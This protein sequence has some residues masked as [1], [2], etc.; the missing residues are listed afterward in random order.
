MKKQKPARKLSRKPAGQKDIGQIISR[1]SPFFLLIIIALGLWLRSADLRA[2][3]PPDLSWS[4]APYT[5]ESLNT[6][7][8]RNY[9][10]YHTFKVDDFFP[11]CVYP[12]VNIIVGFIFK[13]F[14]I[15][16]VQVKLLSVIAGV[17]GILVI[18]FFVKTSAGEI[19]GLFSSLLLATC[20]PLVM[21]SRLGLVETVQ[22]LFL[23]LA[24]LFWSKGLKKP[25]LLIFS[26]LFCAGTFLLVKLSGVFIVGA[27]FI[28]FLNQALSVLKKEIT[29]RHLLL[30]LLWFITGICLAVL[31]WLVLVFL[32]YRSE[33][34]QYVLRHSTESPAGHPRTITAY[35]FNTFTIGLRSRLF[36]RTVWMALIGYLTLPLLA[37]KKNPALFYSLLWLV[38]GMLMLGYM[39]YRPPRY[40]IILLP[41]LIIAFSSTLSN[42]WQT[43]TVIPATRPAL[44][45]T[46]ASALFFWPLC[47]QII[48]YLSGF[49]A[50]PRPGAE[51]GILIGALAL[52]SAFCLAGYLA[53]RYLRSGLVIT[54]PALRAVL[55]LI[56][57]VPTLRLDIG[58]FSDWFNNR[59]YNLIS[60]ARD[61]NQLLPEGAVVAG[62]W[63]PPLMIESR[64]RAVCVTDWANMEGLIERFGV[65]HLILGENEADM[66]LREKIDPAVWE[67]SKLVRRY[68]VRGQVLTVYA[69]P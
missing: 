61:L 37:R 13:I 63:A 20:Y 40:E 57:L 17:L 48:L 14:G 29:P 6:Y 26:G 18:F 3:P 54:P 11:F 52:S 49:R 9:A 43:G 55:L 32:P 58:Q 45:T 22:I 30:D 68:T 41:P 24:G 38:M 51:A 47:L 15:G 28:L 53:F 2:D 60:Y 10:L 56:L 7:S 65:T 12:L 19:A 69:L 35:L 25:Y 23:L 33:Y 39:N 21:Y 44:K 66:K 8:A 34:I 67:K 4:F 62:S 59:T 27:F 1:F 36:P 64:Q 42:L 16:F 5:D 31:V 50:F 46:I